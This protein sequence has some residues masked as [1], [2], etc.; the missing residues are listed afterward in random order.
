MELERPGATNGTVSLSARTEPAHRFKL[1]NVTLPADPVAQLKLAELT[2]ARLEAERDRLESLVVRLGALAAEFDAEGL[3][4]GVTEA[5]RDLT[6]ATLAMFVP[7]ELA[8][9]SQPTVICEPGAL[10]E[11]PEPSRVPVLAGTLWR[12][13]PVRLDD[14]LQADATNTG[15]GRFSDGKPFRSWVGAPVR[16]RYGDA[17]GALFLAHQ[18]PQA[19]GAREE[20]MVQGLAAHLGAS[21]DN[22]AVF[23]ERSG[24]ARALQQTLLPPELPEIPGVDFASRYRPAKS[25]ALVGGD[26]YDMFEVRPGV[27]SLIMGDV[28]GVGPEA[29]ALTGIAR[30]AVRALASQG[31]S[32]AKILSQLNDTLVRFGLQDRF[33]TMLYAEL[34]PDGGVLRVKIANGGHPY[35]L[36]LRADGWVEELD[37]QGTLLG[38]LNEVSLDERD[39][40]L[41]PGDLLVGYTDGVTEARDPSGAFF[42][43]DGLA[44]VLVGCAGRP[45]A[46]VAQRIELAVLEHQAGVTPDDVAIVVVQVLPGQV[47]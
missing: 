36:L 33:C 10:G 25:M 21:L 13:T 22:L 17:L 38:M 37:I 29:A 44:N 31:A 5:A 11:A 7:T 39:V 46:W 26:F 40:E 19:F 45:A 34:R 16:A 23:Q 18:C 9:V 3:V 1:A 20:E 27:W 24:V 6:G 41:G 47:G 2:I 35:P 30:Y 8:A 12:V 42:G 14:A 32:P 4:Q 15:Y 43:P 28:S